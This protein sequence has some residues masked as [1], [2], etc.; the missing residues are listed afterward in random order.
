MPKR[1]GTQA[2]GVTIMATYYF[3]AFC[4]VEEGGYA[5]AFPDVPEAISEGKDLAEAMEMASDALKTSLEEYAKARKDLPEPST[6]EC[7]RQATEKENK[8]MG[9]EPAGEVLYQLIAAPEV[10]RTPVKVT[11]SFPRNVLDLID[12]HAKL[13]GRTRSGYLADLA[14][15]A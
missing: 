4:P 14:L 7:V 5:V 8:E 15:N 2:Q 1:G 9:F 10:D 3:A 6:L 11:L 12:S 13:A